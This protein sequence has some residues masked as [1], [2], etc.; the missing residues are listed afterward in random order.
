MRHFIRHTWLPIS[1]ILALMLLLAAIVASRYLFSLATQYYVQLNQVRLDPF[2]L[3]YY[4]AEPSPA[5]DTTRLVFFG[6][7]RAQDWPIPPNLPDFEF[8]NR[9]IGGQTTAQVAGRFAAHITPLQPDYILL[10]VGVNDLKT[11]P[12]F[13]DQRTVIVANCLANIRAILQQS[14]DVGATVILTTIFP[15]SEASF[16]RRLFFW[17]DGVAQAIVEVNDEI[18]SMASDTVMILDSYALL[19][20]ENGLTRPDYAADT[21]HLNPAGYTTLNQMLIALL[22]SQKPIANS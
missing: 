10:Q 21:L 4:A 5:S 2:D 1:L 19:V 18:R 11:I 14:A 20:G 22:D 9:G 15:V 3:Q 16:E 13:P 6:D 8:I 17:S 12:I 7:S